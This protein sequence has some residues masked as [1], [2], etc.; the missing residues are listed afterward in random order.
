MRKKHLIIIITLGLYLSVSQTALAYR[1]ELHPLMTREAINL[2]GEGEDNSL[3]NYLKR[4]LGFENGLSEEFIVS[5]QEGSLNKP[6][7]K[8]VIEQ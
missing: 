6:D 8:R 3:D 2:L 1:A 5:G 7:T 4:N